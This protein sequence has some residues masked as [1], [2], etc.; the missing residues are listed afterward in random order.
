MYIAIL[1][2]CP[3]Q[4]S[5]RQLLIIPWFVVSK[6][7]H[8]KNFGTRDLRHANLPHRDIASLSSTPTSLVKENGS[9]NV[10]AS[11]SR[12]QTPVDE[13]VAPSHSTP[14]HDPQPER[15]EEEEEAEIGD[16]DEDE[17]EKRDQFAQL[18]TQSRFPAPLSSPQRSSYARDHTN[19]GNEASTPPLSPTRTGG[20]LHKYSKSAGT[21]GRSHSSAT[22]ATTKIFSPLVPTSTGTAI[23]AGTGTRYGIALTGQPTGESP[24]RW[25]G[26]SGTPS[27]GKC[28][29]SVYFAE[30]IKAIGKTYHKGCLRCTECNTS[31]DSTR[32]TEKDGNPLCHR[33]YAKVRISL[34]MEDNHTHIGFQLHG[35]QGSGYALLGK[36][37]G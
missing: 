16:E 1:V 7:C 18:A 8:V 5:A 4:F 34:A 27:C 36:A 2:K 19:I 6:S 20:F 28:G 24:T 33:C 21:L 9:K 15:D 3:S 30:Q 37:G 31:L 12:G 13:D 26:A 11:S 17:D 14:S 29:K 35:P 32:L 10:P 23:G 25:G 22:P